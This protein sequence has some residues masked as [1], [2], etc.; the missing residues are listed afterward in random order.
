MTIVVDPSDAS[1]RG[2]RVR[3]S[4]ATPTRSGDASVRRLPGI[5]VAGV[6]SLGA[7]AVHAA[8]TGI[9]AEH[10]DLAR[11]LRGGRGA[12]ARRGALEPAATGTMGRCRDGGGERRGRGRVGGHPVLGISW[13]DGTESAEAPQFADAAC[14]LLGAVAAGAALAVALVGW[15]RACHLAC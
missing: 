13:I 6:A 9:H 10:P 11:D 2:L 8:A 7:G 1:R 3:T 5:V 12:A 4:P 14:A 15:Q